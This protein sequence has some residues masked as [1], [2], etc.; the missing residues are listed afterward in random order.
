MCVLP[1]IKHDT[2]DNTHDVYYIIIETA[3]KLDY[4]LIGHSTHNIGGYCL[5]TDH[6]E[7]NKLY[8]VFCFTPKAWFRVN[9]NLF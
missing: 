3:L 2:H 1:C 9:L 7:H 5:F 8:T 4:E 6:I